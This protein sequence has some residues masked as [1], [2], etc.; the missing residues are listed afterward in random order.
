[1]NRPDWMNPQVMHINREAP[2]ATL[3]PF[4][5]EGTALAGERGLSKYYRLLNGNWDFL[6]CPDGCA[7]EGF[8]SPA[9][10][11]MDDGWAELPVPAN[12][13]M[14]GYDIPQYTNVNYPIPVDP[15]FVPD[16]NPVGCYRRYFTLPEDWAGSEVFI[17]FDGVDSAYYVY[18]NG[19]MAGFSK[20][21]HM[22]AEFNITKYLHAGDNLVAVK[23]FKWSD[24]TY[25]EDQDFWRLSGIFRDVYLLGVPKVTLRNVQAIATLENDYKDGKLA[26]AIEPAN[27]T[28]KEQAAKITAKLMYKGAVIEEKAAEAALA[29]GVGKIPMEFSVPGCDAWTAETPN[30]YTL[31]VEIE[32][33]EGKLV[34]RID[35]GFKTVEIRDQQLFVNGVSIKLRGVNRHDTHYELGHVTPMESLILD[36]EL[37]KK[38]NVNTVRTS[39][40]PNDPRWLKLCDEYGLYVIDEAD[41][42]THGM[43]AVC[44][45]EDATAEERFSAW[46]SLS[47]SE[48]WTL[49]YVDRAERMVGRDLN[50]ASIIIWSLGNESGCGRNHVAMKK[51][52]LE[53]DQTRPIHYEGDSPRHAGNTMPYLVTDIASTMYPAVEVLEQEGLSDDPHPFFMCEYTHGMGLGPGSLKEYWETIYAHKR[54]IGGCVWEWVDHGMLVTD[55][56]GVDYY[57]YGGDFGDYPNDNNFCIDAFNYP[58]RTPHT[59]LIELK[60]AYEP[61][62][63]ELVDAEKGLLKIRNL[64]AFRTLDHLDAAW[65]VVVDGKAV[66]QGRLCLCGVA[67]YG[68]KTV[69][70]GY[71]LPVKGAAYLEITVS[72]AFET[73]WATRGHEISFT[74][75][76]LPVAVK[77]YAM[78]AANMPSLMLE[79][80]ADAALITGEDFQLLFDRRTGALISWTNAGVELIEDGPQLNVWRAPTDN[81]I[82]IKEKWIRHGLDKLQARVTGFAVEQI[83]EKIVRVTVETVHAA[84]KLAPEIGAAFVY[85]VFGNGDVRVSVTFKPLR[86][87][88]PW[89]PKLGVQFAL[90]GELDRVMWF[91]RG[92]HENYE[93]MCFSAPVGLY[94]STVEDLHEPYVRPQEN[95][96][97]GDVQVLAVTDVL[98]AGIMFV[99][100]KVYGDGFSFTAHNYSDEALDA[101]TH[102]NELEAEDMTTLSIDYRQCGLGSNIC[103]PEP[104]EQYKIYLTEPVEFTFVM[105]PYNRQLGDMMVLGRV[106]PE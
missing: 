31:L 71:K 10:D 77:N 12:W 70:L 4:P 39:H 47:D 24:G 57:A 65:A 5:C 93:D 21:P 90:P 72:D 89:L 87:T 54:L 43:G 6:Y 29:A 86:D 42:E 19:E 49:A 18:I 99:G 56:D 14:Y 67:P 58:D 80:S 85:T 60:K 41:L 28:D 2:R 11:E 44:T 33:A 61:V 37:M 96:A 7:P 104:Q 32:S 48:E 13:Q 53:L 81:D 73:K 36:V 84:D 1:M 74:Q 75:L 79:E 22:P 97:R 17:N 102:T 83:S 52:M 35:V 50:H 9:Y 98:G 105:R 62:K 15:P 46:S 55:D 25:L 45:K 8:E 20:V 95:G 92:P 66:E 76:A 91:G 94:D 27:Y 103:G 69:E 78:P 100:E 51:R 68:E 30:L 34:Q 26:L 16:D 88:L 3:V 38:N 64:Y 59:G 40:Y 23:V 63:F 106:L 101:A 82:H